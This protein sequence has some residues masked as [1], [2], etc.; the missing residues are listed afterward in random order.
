[1][2]E[3]RCPQCNTLL[4]KYDDSQISDESK[5]LIETRHR[6]GFEHY[7]KVKVNDVKVIEKTK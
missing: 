2:K 1:M 3:H 6:C 7:K 5:V 4:F